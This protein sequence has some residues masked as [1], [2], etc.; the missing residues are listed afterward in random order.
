M[1]CHSEPPLAAELQPGVCRGVRNPTLGS[2]NTSCQNKARPD[3]GFNVA[4]AALI[5]FIFNSAAARTCGPSASVWS[6]W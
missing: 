6:G 2:A 5:S 3:Y 1:T 4:Y